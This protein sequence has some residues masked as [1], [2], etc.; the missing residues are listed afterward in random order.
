MAEQTLTVRDASGG[1]QPPS[2]PVT[3]D[4]SGEGGFIYKWGR[5]YWVRVLTAIAVG[6]LFLAGA[7]WAWK[8][9]ATVS[10]P[11]KGYD[12]S[13][14]LPADSKIEPGAPASFINVI[15]GKDFVLGTGVVE[16]VS[17]SPDGKRATLTIGQFQAADG[18]MR[19]AKRVDIGSGDAALKTNVLRETGS[20]VK[21]P[22]FS[23]TYLQGGV[24][25]ALLLVGLFA[26][27][28]FVGRKPSSVDFLIATDE[29]MRKVNWSTRQTI[30]NS[31]MVVISATFLI[32][33]FIFLWDT[34]LK[35]ALMDWIVA[36]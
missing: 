12:A 17:A 18:V 13:V 28:T 10:L 2:T 3:R 36:W 30:I 9:L 33:G 25:G 16:R 6:M 14:S 26:I 5:G 35:K 27:Y 8:N 23:P 32:A 4:A 20:L 15:D 22:V 1:N 11:A 24:A 21:I 7:G 29:E 34:I 19:D 31:T